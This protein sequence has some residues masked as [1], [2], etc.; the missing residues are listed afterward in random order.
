R[1]VRDRAPRALRRAARPRRH[2][3]RE[4]NGRASSQPF[5]RWPGSPAVSRI[6]PAR[7]T[8]LFDGSACTPPEG[9]GR[10]KKEQHFKNFLWVSTVLSTAI[11]AACGGGGSSD[12]PAAGPTRLALTGVAA[13]GAP[14]AGQLVEAKCS[15]G[16]GTAT[17]NA[18]GSY[19]IS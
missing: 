4:C 6:R 2:P 13:T 11:L 12:G 19:T 8:P 16:T 5:G 1:V 10:S 18:D 3:S 9:A 7:Q 14:I 15:S 17:S